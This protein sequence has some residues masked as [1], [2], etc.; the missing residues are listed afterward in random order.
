MS[1]KNEQILPED[2][3]SV[4]NAKK[5]RSI[6]M[7]ASIVVA[8][9]VL[10]ILLYIFAY[11]QPAIKKGDEAIAPAD[12]VALFEDNDSTALAMYEAVANEQGFGAGN[13]ATLEVAIRQYEKGDYAK[14][15]EYINKYDASDNVVGALAYGLKG[16]C[17]VNLDKYGDAVK[18]FNKAIK[19][20]DNNPQLVPY[21]MT[22]KAV[23]L[24]AQEK[25]GDAAKIYSEIETKYPTFAAQNHTESRRIQAEAFAG[26]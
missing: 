14:A 18:A 5:A 13:R 8:L 19:Q 21:F 15:L 9:I 16:D 1:T 4:K 17:L 7:W 10:G 22:K 26:K 23:V 12:R 25:Y 6:M 20:A 11:R 24:C 2:E 3:P